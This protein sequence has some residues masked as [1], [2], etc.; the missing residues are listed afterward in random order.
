MGVEIEVIFFNLMQISD[1]EPLLKCL[2]EQNTADAAHWETHYS[3]LL[4]FSMVMKI[5][6]TLK[7]FDSDAT[8]SVTDR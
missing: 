3:L 6:F 5:P 7:R 2:E 8:V 1:L 4:W